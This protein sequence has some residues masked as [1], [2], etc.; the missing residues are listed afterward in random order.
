MLAKRNIKDI[1]FKNRPGTG[2]ERPFHQQKL[3]HAGT[4]NTGL[5]QKPTRF[6]RFHLP[7]PQWKGHRPG[8]QYRGIPPETHDHP[9]RITGIPC[10]SQ[11]DLHV[12][13]GT[14]RNQ[15]S[16]KTTPLQF[17]LLQKPGRNTPFHSER[18]RGIE[19]QE[20]TTISIMTILLK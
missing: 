8:T 7:G 2:S 19:T 14:G 18:F 4:G 6:W 13:H 17:Q 15:S 10:Y 1:R 16:E 9:R 5:H 11:R 12:A 3:S 20:T